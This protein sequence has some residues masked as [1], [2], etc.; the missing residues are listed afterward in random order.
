MSSILPPPLTSPPPTL[1]SILHLSL[2]FV[3]FI[4]SLLLILLESR[5]NPRPPRLVLSG[6]ATISAPSPP[7][8]STTRTKP[9]KR[10]RACI[11]LLRLLLS[12]SL[13]A[14]LALS[15]LSLIFFIT[16]PHL[17]TLSSPAANSFAHSLFQSALRKYLIDNPS[18]RIPPSATVGLS[19]ALISPSSTPA[20]HILYAILL[21]AIIIISAVGLILAVLPE[22]LRAHRAVAAIIFVQAVAWLVA[23]LVTTLVT[24]SKLPVDLAPLQRHWMDRL[25]ADNPLW[26]NET[27][28]IANWYFQNGDAV[29]PLSDLANFQ[30]AFCA[31]FNA[32]VAGRTGAEVIDDSPAT[33]APPPTT[34]ATSTSAA[35]SD[36]LTTT[37]VATTTT[38]TVAQQDPVTSATTVDAGDAEDGV[39]TEAPSNTIERPTR[40]PRI[41]RQAAEPDGAQAA[42]PLQREHAGEFML[43]YLV[44]KPA[45]DEGVFRVL[46]Y[47]ALA[48][49]AGA[50]A[51]VGQL[52]RLWIL[53]P[54]VA[55]WAAMWLAFMLLGTPSVLRVLTMPVREAELFEVCG[56]EYRIL[57]VDR[58]TRVVAIL[59]ATFF[60][61]VLLVG[62]VNGFR[63]LR[64]GERKMKSVDESDVK[65]VN[66]E[67]VYSGSGA[68]RW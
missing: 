6:D 9:P 49:M 34:P 14:S 40:R 56:V 62:L 27:R 39:A 64:F 16:K 50:P 44:G 12:V 25:Y 22:K 15:T 18:V 54:L 36:D 20:N 23:S 24:P 10:A 57:V 29:R 43:A 30:V 11:A 31:Q 7:T 61:V 52:C 8:T 4:V 67:E 33:P 2:A 68:L 46:S 37:A 41:V 60:S 19:D 48:A 51:V 13:A 63:W 55:V 65:L 45:G 26:V 28:M 1:P 53:T 58:M 35:A 42:P 59:D 66:Y 3:A 21:A 5:L 32:L 47:M 17:N 38:T